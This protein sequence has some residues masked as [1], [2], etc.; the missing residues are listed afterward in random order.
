[1]CAIAESVDM[2]IDPDVLAAQC[3]LALASKFNA[4]I[5][6]DNPTTSMP[7]PLDLSNRENRVEPQL[8]VE[9]PQKE[10]SSA[11]QPEGTSEPTSQQLQ[12]PVFVARILADLSSAR[13]NTENVVKQSGSAKK[14]RSRPT[15]TKPKTA[16]IH[17]CFEPDCGKEYGK[18]SHLKAHERTHTGG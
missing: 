4:G 18:S 12:S 7:A 14:T 15:K 1:V 2:M 17:K 6:Q 8:P 9:S 13:Q 11:E 3:L 16:K 5:V 10:S